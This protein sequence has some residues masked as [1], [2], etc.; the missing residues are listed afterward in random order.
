MGAAI[1][2]SCITF[3][4]C[5]RALPESPRKLRLI[6]RPM[7]AIG[8]FNHQMVEIHAPRLLTFHFRFKISRSTWLTSKSGLGNV[9]KMLLK[10]PDQLG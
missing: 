9:T 7:L 6:V 3:K 5:F 8:A 2:F 4:R 10:F 1:F